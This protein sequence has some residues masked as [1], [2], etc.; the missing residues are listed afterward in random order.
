MTL[1]ALVMVALGATVRA[2]LPEGWTA[3]SGEWSE[4]RELIT[5]LHQG[6]REGGTA[7]AP[8]TRGDG[9]AWRCTVQPSLDAQACGLWFAASE[10]LKTGFR[11][12]LGPT[13]EKGLSLRD[14]E[15]NVLWSD[16]W[17]PCQSYRAYILEG[18]AEP[19]RV[20]IQLLSYDRATPLSQSEWI[21]TPGASASGCLGVYT[22]TAIAR[23]WDAEHSDTPLAEPTET[24]PNKMRLYQG[25]ESDWVVLGTGDWRWTSPERTR[26]RQFAT[27]ERAWALLRTETGAHRAWQS[28]A[29]VAEG[30]GGA[31]SCRRIS[32]P[33]TPRASPAAS[34]P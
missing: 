22:E 33:T 29:R 15:G 19:G 8:G 10:D 13:G 32:N 1:L 30:A 2:D 14:A 28:W 26:I 31:G 12:E 9:G 18:V 34:P 6:S 7:V 11:C 23:F 20:R 27:T 5:M 16:P 24:A 4:T 21:E 3:L 17:A 25:P